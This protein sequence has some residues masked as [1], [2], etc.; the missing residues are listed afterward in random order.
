VDCSKNQCFGCGGGWPDRAI[1]Y[2]TTAGAVSDSSYPY[3]AVQQSTCGVSAS[4]VVAHVTDYEYCTNHAYMIRPKKACTQSIFNAILTNGPGSILIDASSRDFQS[5]KSGV[6]VPTAADC[7]A[8]NHAV[9]VVGYT[10]ATNVYLV[11]NS[12]NTTWGAKGYVNF[13]YDASTFTCLMMN[14]IWR[15]IAN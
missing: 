8:E 12:W 7:K 13:Q 5:Y 3:K 4:N 2:L 1:T 9:V 6:F 10:S 14:N 15:P 11:R